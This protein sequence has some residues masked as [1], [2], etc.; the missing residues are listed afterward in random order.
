MLLRPVLMG[1]QVLALAMAEPEAMPARDVALAPDAF[2][3]IC[4][5]TSLASQ[6]R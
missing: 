2:T 5:T 1:T 4:A 3:V 6:P